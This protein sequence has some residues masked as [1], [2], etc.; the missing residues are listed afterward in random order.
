MSVLATRAEPLPAD[1]LYLGIMTSP[2]DPSAAIVR[3]GQVLALADEERFTRTKHSFGAYPIQAVRYCLEAAGTG[4]T[5]VHQIAMP[6]DVAAYSGGR[7]EA[8]YDK[9]ADCYDVDAA[10]RGW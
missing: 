2:H 8:F 10:T 1:R 7:I 3:D 9:M 6:W 4:L 5:G